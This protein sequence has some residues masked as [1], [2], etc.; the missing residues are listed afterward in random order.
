MV[1]GHT[2][3]N[4]IAT[5]KGCGKDALEPRSPA[6]FPRKLAIPLQ[7]SL[8]K[9]WQ[10]L[11]SEFSKTTPWF[12]RATEYLAAQLCRLV[13]CENASDVLLSKLGKG[14]KPISKSGSS[15]RS[16]AMLQEIH[17][18]RE[19]SQKCLASEPVEDEYLVWLGS[20][21]QRYLNQE[22]TSLEEALGL[23]FAKGGVPWWLEEAIRVRDAAL[24]A[25]ADQVYADHCLTAKAREV[26]KLA[27]RYAASA[28]RFDRCRDAMPTAYMGTPKQHLWVAFSSGAAMPLSERQLR[29]VLAT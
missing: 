4:K 7:F 11:E 27:S 1:G 15:K 10:L 12:Q 9:S 14:T 19:I 25:L 21:F 22:C 29:N 28:W 20:A 26:R 8:W 18:L 23:R 2:N 13:L 6:N 3:K 5:L 17:K 24:R 16:E